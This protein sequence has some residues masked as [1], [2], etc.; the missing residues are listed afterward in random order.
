MINSATLMKSSCL[1]TW[2][3]FVSFN[4]KEMFVAKTFRIS[5]LFI[6]PAHASF[7]CAVRGLFTQITPFYCNIINRLFPHRVNHNLY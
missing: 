3:A 6:M 7:K 1:L 5:T 4:W 2:C